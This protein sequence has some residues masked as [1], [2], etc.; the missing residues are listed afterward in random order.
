MIELNEE[1]KWI[2]GMPLFECA[3]LAQRLRELG[4]DIN[5]KA[6][7]EQAHVIHFFLS[8][9]EEHG[10]NWRSYASSYLRS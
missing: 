1:T 8:K 9:Y 6:E 10:E 3:V 4:H 5:F 7:D 2:F